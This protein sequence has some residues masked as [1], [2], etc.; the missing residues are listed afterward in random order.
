MY[1]FWEDQSS[2]SLCFKGQESGQ[3]IIYSEFLQ[4]LSESTDVARR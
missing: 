3:T 4:L 1:S 2:Q